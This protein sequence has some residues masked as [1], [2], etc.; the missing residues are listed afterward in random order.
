MVWFNRLQD[1]LWK[2]LTV[3]FIQHSGGQCSLLYCFRSCVYVACF[4]MSCQMIWDWFEQDV[5]EEETGLSSFSSSFSL[6]PAVHLT[7]AGWPAVPMGGEVKVKMLHHISLLEIWETW[8]QTA[9]PAFFL[10]SLVLVNVSVRA[11]NG[12]VLKASSSSQC[13]SGWPVAFCSPLENHK[14]ERLPA[15]AFIMALV[16]EHGSLQAP[17]AQQ[18]SSVIYCIQ[19]NNLL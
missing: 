11:A 2:Q 17:I 12:R 16:T 18:A 4:T 10:F 15:T 6:L 9:H 19:P 3:L 8:S 5:W 13:V 14:C 7:A 1:I